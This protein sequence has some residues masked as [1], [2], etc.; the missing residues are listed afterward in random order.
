MITRYQ[1]LTGLLNLPCMDRQRNSPLTQR[2]NEIVATPKKR[3]I[4]PEVGND[5]N[6][7]LPPPKMR[8]KIKL[9]A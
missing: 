1:F 5:L 4:Y 7:S 2:T 3:R 6:E 9:F 8:S